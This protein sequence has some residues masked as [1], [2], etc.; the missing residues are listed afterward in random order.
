MPE[1][2]GGLQIMQYEFTR[3][4]GVEPASASG[5]GV[6]A[7]GASSA[8]VAVGEY[9]A[10]SFGGITFYG[11][12][13]SAEAATERLTGTEYAFQMVDNRVRLGWAI[14]FGQWNMEEDPNLIHASDYPAFPSSS[15]HSGGTDN[16]V[17]FGAGL[18]SE[19]SIPVSSIVSG[20]ATR[21]RI[22]GCIPPSQW[23]SQIKSYRADPLSAAD[24]LDQAF[25]GALGG[26]QFTLSNHSA[27]NRPVFNVDAN[28]GMT[29]AALVALVTE[30]QGLQVTLDG[31]KTLRWARRGGSVV[32]PGGSHITRSGLAMSA[33]PTKV[34]VVGDRILLQSNNILLEPD[35]NEEWEPFVSEPAWLAEV[36]RITPEVTNDAAGHAEIAARAREMTVR[37]Y[38][39]LSGVSESAFADYGR[40]GK[41]SRL[42]MEAW[43]YLNSIVYRSYRIPKSAMLCGMPMRHWE[44][45]E[46]LLCAVTI[47]GSGASGTAIAYRTDPVEYYPQASSYVIA[48]GQPLDLL[49]ASDR[50][51][52]TRLRMKDLR[53]QWSEVPDF[54]LDALNHSINFATP[55]FRDGDPATG[56]SILAFVNKGEAGWADLSETLAANE[57][58]LRIAVPNPDYEI[59]AAP[60]RCSLTFR[61]GK[62]Y[63]DFGT[64]AKWTVYSA[65]SLTEHL[66]H[67]NGGNFSDSLV[68]SYTGD[69]RVPNAPGGL[70]EIRYDNGNTAREEAA[71]Q[72]EGLIVKSGIEQSGSYTRYGVAGTSLTGA[73]DRVTIMISGIED[74]L[75]EIVEFAKPR[76]TQ[77]F[78]SSRDSSRRIQTEELY[79]GREELRREV[80]QLKSIARIEREAKNRRRSKSHQQIADIFQN[81]FGGGNSSGTTIPDPNSAWPEGRVGITGWRAGDLLWLDGE[82][83]PSRTGQTFGGVVVSDSH[84]IDGV[85]VKF[86]IVSTDGTVP[87][88]CAPGLTPSSSLSAVP[89]DWKCTAAGTYPVGMLGHH[90][91]VPGS[92][93]ATL[94]LVRLNAGGG[95]SSA[96]TPPL[97]LVSSRPSYIPPGTP[98]AEGYVGTWLTW[99]FANGKL[100]TNWTTR[101]DSELLGTYE[102]YFKL[103]VNL[104][105]T[106]PLV[107]TSCAWEAWAT[108][109]EKT[110][111]AWGTNGERPAFIY[112]S[113]G[114]L[115][116]IDGVSQL[117]NVG[118][119]SVNFFEHLSSISQNGHA[120]FTY[121]KTINHNRIP[122]G[123]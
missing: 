97:Y 61:L 55:I 32:V 33:E 12:I 43:T 100:A 13:S 34:R 114:A 113:L 122:Y 22:Y 3:S 89:G 44:I 115:F 111:A 96:V 35:W 49:D 10:F 112:F 92:G 105:P 72:A 106:G 82:G 40:W 24:I 46:N 104:T 63:Q 117:V 53:T 110:D 5:R 95:G 50:D 73:T 25:K 19:P 52:L 78:V 67:S 64:G 11:I 4:W 28:N 74:G 120:G 119:G 6:V 47:S 80:R 21:G 69:L 27:Q 59:S 23:A 18:G 121:S 26:Y 86:V 48:Q 38:I 93:E 99:G 17:D 84:K 101:I 15:G 65:S 20:S 8:G 9:Y 83:R 77:G 107:V 14:V 116:V 45:H 66:L 41:V 71:E 1:I 79:G 57:D 62:F 39:Q 70:G 31:Q 87:T 16:G 75:R 91:P 118:A 103:K 54:T 68:E 108:P 76:P 98:V 42:N 109:D 94:A 58:Y 56:K 90:S 2:V 60:V 88:A 29:L 102:K 123:A 30:A 37:E 85:P 7:A 51:I 36:K 81:P